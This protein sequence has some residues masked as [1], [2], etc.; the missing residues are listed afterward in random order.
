MTEPDLPPEPNR[1]SRHAWLRDM[2]LGLM[3]LTRLPV[4]AVTDLQP[5]DLARA[6]WVYPIIGV[7]AGVAGGLAFTVANRAGLGI[8]SATIL[9]IAAQVALTGALHEDGL[10]D[11][12]DGFGGGRNRERKLAIMRDSRIGTYGVMALLIAFG[13]RYAG[14]EE[15]AGALLAV[16]DELDETVSHSTAITIAL[17]TA[18]ALSRAAVV[19]VWCV[20]PPAR[21]DGLAAS[22]GQVPAT[23][24]LVALGLAALIA[25]FLLP[26][27]T[28]FSAVLAAG[29]AATAIAILAR[30]QI[31]GH[32]GDVLGAT[33]QSS[34]IA[35]L[36][37]ISALAITV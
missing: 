8:A 26:I 11:T 15:L 18:G 19:A 17:V 29:I 12:A 33:Q 28:A 32:T 3:L 31:G 16:S 22:A 23:S 6:T 5:N 9:A 36:L 14:L 35:V 27:G 30:R 2:R 25:V 13:L 10:A 24:A 1:S 20:L 7:V 4:P 21:P 37:A 34:E